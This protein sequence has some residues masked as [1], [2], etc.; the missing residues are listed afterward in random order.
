MHVI[1]VYDSRVDCLCKMKLRFDFKQNVIDR[2][3]FVVKNWIDGFP[4]LA[5]VDKVNARYF[6]NF[7]TD[8]LIKWQQSDQVTV[9]RG[10]AIIV[11][12]TRSKITIIFAHFSP[13]S[14]HLPFI[15]HFWLFLF[16]NNNHPLGL[17]R[18]MEIWQNKVLILSS[19]VGHKSCRTELNTHLLTIYRQFYGHLTQSTAIV[20]YHLAICDQ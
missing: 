14:H 10:A 1:I 9:I 15:L 2:N 8:R 20:G 17:E 12:S 4:S 11:H 5:S 6:R 3:W 16:R 19:N 18:V 13:C 7:A